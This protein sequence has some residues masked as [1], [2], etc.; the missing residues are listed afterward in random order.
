MRHDL[1]VPEQIIINIPAGGHASR[2]LVFDSMNRLY[3][4]VGRY[5]IALHFHLLHFAVQETLM[6]IREELQFIDSPSKQIKLKH[7]L[8]SLLV[9]CSLME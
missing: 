2:T 4:T 9:K 1:G 7:P 5:C 8:T 6:Q 3:V